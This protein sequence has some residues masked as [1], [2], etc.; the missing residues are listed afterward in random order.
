MILPNAEHSKH[1]SEVAEAPDLR[2]KTIRWGI[3]DSFSSGSGIAQEESEES[4]G[5]YS[6]EGRSGKDG[7]GG[8]DGGTGEATVEEG[9]EWGWGW[10]PE[11]DRRGIEDSDVE[12]C[13]CGAR[14]HRRDTWYHRRRG[15]KEARRRR[16]NLVKQASVEIA[17]WILDFVG[18]EDLGS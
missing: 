12:Y 1:I 9:A 2:R 15:E 6:E 16:H 8:C 11:D 7:G 10:E 5:A 17:H 4:R 14:R 13:H 3:W 18:S